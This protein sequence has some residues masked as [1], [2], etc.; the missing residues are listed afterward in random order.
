MVKLGVQ[1][2]FHYI[3]SIG[4]LGEFPFSIFSSA[5]RNVKEM[6]PVQG[7]SL[8]E[9]EQAVFRYEPPAGMLVT[10]RPILSLLLQLSP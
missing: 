4:N 3:T 2:C 8:M 6:S 9:H 1:V 5:T 7:Q 10:H